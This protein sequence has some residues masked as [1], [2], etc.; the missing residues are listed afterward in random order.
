MRVV[1]AEDSLLLREGLVRLLDEAGASV[2]A[3]VGDGK[4][5]VEAVH[6]HR[7]DVAVVDVR[8]PPT[9]T[10]EGLRAAL[11]VRRTVPGT[12]ILVLSQYVEESYASDLLTAG[13]GVGYLL[14]DRVAKLADLSDA[15]ERVVDGGTVLDPEVV[16]ALFAHRRRRDPLSTLSPREREVLGL[17]A[18][19][20]TNTAIGRTLVITQG[21]VEKHISSIF[22]KLG[23]PPS[24]DDHRR[25]MAVLTWLGV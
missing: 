21:A 2:V 1:L 11:E 16:S 13:G 20:R 14:K 24:G 10:D 9:F 3:A 12:A 19:G 8:M 15:L 4:A 18:E 22:T 5:L 23:L 7:P 17:M 25:V 6:E